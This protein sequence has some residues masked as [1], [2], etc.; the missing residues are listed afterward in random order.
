[1]DQDSSFE[2][3]GIN[4][5]IA[6]IDEVEAVY[7]HVA[8][9]TPYHLVSNEL[10]PATKEEFTEKKIV[11]TSGNLLNLDAYLTVGDFNENLFIDYVDYE[12]CLRLRN[13]NFKIIQNNSVWLKHS[14]GDFSVRNFLGIKIGVSNH[15]Y[16]RRYY[17]TRNS[18]YV[19]FRYLKFEKRFFLNVLLYTFLVDP[20]L[21]I[22]YEKGKLLKLQS[23]YKGCI[24]FLT[25]K[26]GQKKF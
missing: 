8:I 2:A 4:K 18:L 3:N 14:L 13:H 12:Y 23:V 17:K 15:N 7:E 16:I 19:G 10:I 25:G 5:L 22:F 20:F 11:M 9:I 24:D 26:Y 21:I 6:S 1:M